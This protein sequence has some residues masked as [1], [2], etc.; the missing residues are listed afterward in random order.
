MDH[1][2]RLALLR[3]HSPHIRAIDP[4]SPLQLG[5]GSLA[6]AMDLTG[7]QTFP[8]AYP[9]GPGS[10][11]LTTMAEWGWFAGRPAPLG[12]VGLDLDPGCGPDELRQ[13]EQTLDLSLGLLVSR[14]VLGRVR[15]VVHCL[16]DSRTD[17][18]VVRL[19]QIGSQRAGLRLTLP[20]RL[21]SAGAGGGRARSTVLPDAAGWLIEHALGDVVYWLRLTAPGASLTQVGDHDFVLR[22]QAG[23]PVPAWTDGV[24]PRASDWLEAVI[25]FA[26]QPPP[27]SASVDD[28]L[29]STALDWRAYWHSGGALDLSNS[30]QPQAAELERR[31]LLSQY[32]VRINQAGRRP[33][34]PGG[35]TQAAEGRPIDLTSHV[36]QYAN[37]AQWGRPELLEPILTWYGDRLDQAL[38]QAGRIGSHGAH[39]PSQAEP[40]RLWDDP[41]QLLDPAQGRSLDQLGGRGDRPR[42]AWSQ[43]NPIYLAELAYRAHP[44]RDQVLR[45]GPLVLATAEHMV[46]QIE[47]GG[48]PD[49]ALCAVPGRPLAELAAVDPLADP[50]FEAAWWR[51]GLGCAAV[52]AERSGR[53]DLAQAWRAAAERLQAPAPVMGVYPSLGWGPGGCPGPGP[54]PGGHPL[55]LGALGLAPRCG[56]IDESVMT[57]TLDG[58]LDHWPW[59]SVRSGWDRPL[60]AMTATRLHRPD[61]AW[62]ALLGPPPGAPG[63]SAPVDQS[64]LPNGHHW[65]GPDQSSDL[66]GNGGLLLAVGLMA[67][68]WDGSEDR[69]GFSLAWPA[70]ADRVARL[71]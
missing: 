51:W 45:W 61:L 25:A 20:L 32:L 16:V 31:V 67:A 23:W 33:V 29:A 30:E 10:T 56:L 22:R 52:W 19:A 41:A 42:R 68:G 43:V 12:R 2:N 6:A 48:E 24:L 47:T 59:A 17:A 46:A 28:C 39:W 9:A 50:T 37:F 55:H 27:P 13:T 4:R 62:T 63:Q 7:L 35:L 69:P 40:D 14:F 11:L 5:N 3:R 65:S 57:A 38:E 34:P 44:T 70:L 15:H 21:R 54:A 58:V 71:P 64:Y 66:T 36:W 18:L 60:V 8:R 1:V 53:A 26:S 49:Q